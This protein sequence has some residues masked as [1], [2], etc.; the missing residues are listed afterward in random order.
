ML[1]RSL[2]S[3]ILNIRKVLDYHRGDNEGYSLPVCDTVQFNLNLP[4]YTRH[5]PP[6]RYPKYVLSLLG[7]AKLYNRKATDEST[8]LYLNTIL[9]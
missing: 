8:V 5:T 1:F 3:D 6:Q 2:F 9:L 7:Q 4:D